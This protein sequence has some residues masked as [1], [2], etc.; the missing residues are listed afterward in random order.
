M[1]NRACFREAW[2]AVVAA[3]LG[4]LASPAL[5]AQTTADLGMSVSGPGTA[6]AG[7]AFSYSI[8]V[9]NYGPGAATSVTVTDV[10]PTGVTFAS[11]GSTPSCTDNG[12]TVSCL[13]GTLGS[14]G[15]AS[16]TIVAKASAA[17]TI[18]NVVGVIANELDPNI[19]NNSPVP[20]VTT[21]S[22]PVDDAAFVS[23]SAPPAFTCAGAVTGVSVTMRNTGGSVWDS[24]YRLGSQNPQD[25]GTWGIGR[26]FLAAGETVQPGQQ[27]TFTFNVTTPTGPGAYNFQWRM[28]HEGVQWFGAYTP[29]VVVSNVLPRA[30]TPAA[31]SGDGLWVD[32][33]LPAG[34]V[35]AGIWNWD[36]TQAASGS[37][38]NT[39]PGI[40]GFHQHYFYGATQTLS[41]QPGEKLVAYVLLDP[42]NPPQE[43]MLQWNDGTWEHR[44]FWGQD[45]IGWGQAGT[46]SRLPMGALP[47]AGQW[48]RL[49]VPAESL[50]LAGR[51]LN[52][53]AFSLSDGNAWFDRAGA[54]SAPA[55]V[56]GFYTVVPC[57][58]VDT[59]GPVGTYG[60]PALQP[61]AARLLPLAGV[62]GV[63][64]NARAVAVNLTVVAAGAAGNLI[65]YPAG[66]AIPGTS[67]INFSG[68]QTRANNAVISVSQ[69]GAAGIAIYNASAGSNQ[70][71]IDVVGYFR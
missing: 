9:A 10:L 42:C 53:M 32:D 47:A 4:A 66:T 18:L 44:A 15:S 57:R 49:E 28:V 58:V 16:V 45:F 21:I 25:N 20:W 22:A 3:F 61:N 31:T 1:A 43:V 60:G 68:G 27:K 14:G 65:A 24:T 8:S 37:Q 51:P 69:D 13:I 46:A 38:S 41:V 63:P 67:V 70:L 35:A 39:E 34:A 5:T 23:Q 19:A 29:N 2:R 54:A 62:C 17:G 59:R 11:A 30:A 40:A 26:V 12:G 6:T 48:A 36:T 7:V 33:A 64:S 56:S 55:G 50:G 71:I 52:G